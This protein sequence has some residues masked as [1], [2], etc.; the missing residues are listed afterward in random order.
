MVP[1]K[2]KKRKKDPSE[3]TYSPTMAGG[4]FSIDK[5]FFINLGL[6]DEGFDIWGKINFLTKI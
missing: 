4:L 2:E 1:E 5:E 6:Y 3:P